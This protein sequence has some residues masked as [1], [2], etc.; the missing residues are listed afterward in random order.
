MEENRLFKI[1][2][3]FNALVIS[4]VGILALLVLM[5]AAYHIY[6]DATKTKNRIDIVN[7]NSEEEVKESFR[8]GRLRHISG[9]ESSM[10]PLMSDQSFSLN[11]S[12]NKSTAS[13]RN[14]LFSNIRTSSNHWLLPT[15]DFLIT[16]YKM[17][18]ENNDWDSDKNVITI[19]YYLVKED[20]NNDKR[21][22]SEDNLTLALSSPDGKIYKEVLSNVDS[23]L[24][25]ELIDTSTVAVVFNRNN[26]GYVSYISLVDFSV[27]KEIALPS[28][29]RP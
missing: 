3:R 28:I 19:F 1:I 4:A 16:E 24:G 2:W 23:I 14:I 17:V 7:V 20:S 27:T 10:L 22:T 25:Y 15:N 9:T 11:Y 12:G 13:T 26:L 18:N 6:K 5:Y 8:L 21:L 29:Q